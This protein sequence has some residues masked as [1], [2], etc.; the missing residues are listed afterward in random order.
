MSLWGWEKVAALSSALHGNITFQEL[1]GK[2]GNNAPWFDKAWACRK[3]PP[4][5]NSLLWQLTAYTYSAPAPG[6]LLSHSQAPQSLRSV[7]AGIAGE[8]HCS[9]S[10]LK[11]FVCK[12]WMWPKETEWSLRMKFRLVDSVRWC[13]KPYQILYFNMCM[14]NFLH[15]DYYLIK[16]SPQPSD[17]GTLLTL[18]YKWE[19][20]AQTRR[21]QAG[22]FPANI[23][24]SA[25]QLRFN[26][27]VIV[28]LCGFDIDFFSFLGSVCLPCYGF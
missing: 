3:T 7:G 26:L 21:D 19:T 24:Y 12:K 22:L 6:Q 23:T 16:P 9:S 2:P 14:G 27:P 17:V 18:F 10:L 8:A 4:I 11:A 28:I 25:L 15:P 1:L 20:E 5:S 13:L